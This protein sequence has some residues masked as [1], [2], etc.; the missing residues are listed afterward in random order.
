MQKLQKGNFSSFSFHTQSTSFPFLEAIH[1]T[2]VLYVL[3]ICMFTLY[4]C[5]VFYNQAS[6]NRSLSSFQSLLLI[7]VNL[8]R[9]NI[10]LYCFSL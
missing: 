9:R 6:F 5:T 10:C 3:E 4:A 7:K 8:C 2:N 1:I